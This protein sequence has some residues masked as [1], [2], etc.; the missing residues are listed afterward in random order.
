MTDLSALIAAA[1]PEQ[2]QAFRFEAI[3]MPEVRRQRNMF[4]AT[5]PNPRF[6]HYTRAEAALEIIKSKRLWLRNATAMVDFREVEH[7]FE[8]LLNWFHADD[9]R[10][11]FVAVFDEIHPGAAV[12]AIKK[13]DEMWQRTDFGVRGHTY[14]ASV[15]EHQ[16]SED[17]HGRLSMWRAFGADAAARVAFVF[18][19]P[20]FS[21][22]AQF[23]Q[24]IF[25]PVAY[26]N[27]GRAHQ[28]I[29]EVLTNVVQEREFLRA[30]PYEQ[31]VSLIYFT[32]ALAAICVKHEGFK[33]EQEWR[34]VYLPNIYPP[35]NPPLLVKDIVAVGGV[36][37]PI[38]KLPLDVSVA[39]EI[40]SLDIAAMFDRLIIGPTRFPFV[41]SE[42]FKKALEDVGVTNAGARVIASTIPIRS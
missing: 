15:S 18:K 32:F 17:N 27:Q 29:E 34:I 35:P 24:C 36:P 25:S 20:P 26:L 3:F 19:V 10:K 14:I 11:R 13:F 22:A 5:N 8:L 12:E 30:A 4:Y 23:L 7:G 9:N 28:I 31:I 42:A 1:T 39:P 2:Q 40:A 21:G 38:Y 41:I 16:P 6:V 33:E 37:Q